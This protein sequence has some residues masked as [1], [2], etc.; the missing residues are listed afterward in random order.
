[1]FVTRDNR[2]HTNDIER[3]YRAAIRSAASAS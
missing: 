2:R 1:M 3:H